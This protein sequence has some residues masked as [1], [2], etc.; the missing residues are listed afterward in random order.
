MEKWLRS[1]A[2]NE[3]IVG[4]TDIT[5]IQQHKLVQKHEHVHEDG[6]G[7]DNSATVV[8][9]SKENPVGSHTRT[10]A[11][12]KWRSVATVWREIR[13]VYNDTKRDFAYAYDGADRLVRINAMYER[14]VETRC[15]IIL[16]IHAEHSALTLYLDNADKLARNYGV[17]FSM[18]WIRR[19]D[20]MNE[21]INY[22][23]DDEERSVKIRAQKRALQAREEFEMVSKRFRDLF[24]DDRKNSTATMSTEATK[25]TTTLATISTIFAISQSTDN[26]LDEISYHLVA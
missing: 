2:A 17:I 11:C 24:D 4:T 20:I 21:N 12:D 14:I 9:S 13:Q 26:L 18:S 15:K 25:T 19:S 5:K 8:T 23:S 16:V 10:T 7:S 22:D 6:N 3:T 1:Y